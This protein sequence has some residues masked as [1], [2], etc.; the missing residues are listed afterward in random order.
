M[1]PGVVGVERHGDTVILTLGHRRS[2]RYADE[3]LAGVRDVEVRG[4]TLAEAFLELT[5]G[6]DRD[7]RAGPDIEASA[8]S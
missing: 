6:R 3:D 4:D 1:L 7:G 5:A 8:A 2:T